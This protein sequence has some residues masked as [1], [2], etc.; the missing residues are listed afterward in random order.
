MKHYLLSVNGK[1]KKVY[2]SREYAV[3][4]GKKTGLLFDIQLIEVAEEDSFY[5]ERDAEEIYILNCDGSKDEITYEVY[6]KRVTSQDP[7]DDSYEIQK[8][9]INCKIFGV[10]VEEVFTDKVTKND[11]KTIINDLEDYLNA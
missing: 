7:S 1:A 4:N 5:F 10:P 2:S 11:F 8:E 3:L 9:V 6:D